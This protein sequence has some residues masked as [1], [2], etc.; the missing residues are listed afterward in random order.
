[1]NL[2]DKATGAAGPGIVVAGAGLAGLVTAMFLARRFGAVTVLEQHGDPRRN[3]AATGRSLTVVLSARGWRVLRELDLD[4]KV[5]DCCLPLRGRCGHL[6]DGR[7]QFTSYSRSGVPI[8]AVEREKLL[9][10]LLDAAQATPGVRILFRQRIKKVDLN[11][12]AVF[13]SGPRGGR[14]ISYD[15]LLGCDGAH[16][17]VRAALVERG[18]R[19]QTGALELA[20]QEIIFRHPYLDRQAMHY[21]PTGDSLFGAFPRKS[22]DMFAGS[23]FF[24]LRGPAPSYAAAA[25][26]HDLTD[27]FTATFPGLA[28]EIPDLS[29]QLREKPVATIPLVR[30]DIWTWRGRV[31]LVGDACHAMAPFMGHGMNCAFEDARTLDDCLDASGDWTGALAAYE[32]A[33]K[34]NADAIADISHEHYQTMSYI[35]GRQ[36]DPTALVVKRLTEVLPDRFVP[37]Y[38]RCC[39][40]EETYA[41]AREQD[42][43]LRELARRLRHELGDSALTI[44]ATELEKY[45]AALGARQA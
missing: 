40:T 6:P 13:A 27:Q 3:M 7:E 25:E 9:H 38:E 45:A 17:A 2:D 29:E 10:V 30:C 42:R 19:D 37:L 35:P 28:E 21:W 5:R 39:F 15:R 4:E 20:Y 34:A 18:A 8:W 23:V 26:G 14:W 33:R 11:R 36:E 31:A 24:R 12:A 32:R 22:S 16:S 41:A 1:M 43:L 44:P